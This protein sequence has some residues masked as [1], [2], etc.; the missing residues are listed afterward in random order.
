[1]STS[2]QAAKEEIRKDLETAHTKFHQLFESLSGQ[3]FQKPSHNSGWANGEI[4]AHMTFGFVVI[5]VLLPR[6]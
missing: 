3:N 2:Y 4:L 5:N 1:M 6:T